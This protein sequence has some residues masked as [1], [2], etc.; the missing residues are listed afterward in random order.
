MPISR[1]EIVNR[2]QALISSSLVNSGAPSWH[3]YTI[4]PTQLSDPWLTKNFL[5]ETLPTW[6]MVLFGFAV[7]STPFSGGTIVSIDMTVG[8]DVAP[9]AFVPTCP[10][11]V[12]SPADTIWVTTNIE[13]SIKSFSVSTPVHVW[14]TAIWDNL[15]TLTTGSAD[16]YLYLSKV[17]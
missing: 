8:T 12:V 5:I 14:V 17:Q 4:D 2:V 16:I 9:T 6:W 10:D 13:N 15:D 1:P 7:I 3:K 11:L